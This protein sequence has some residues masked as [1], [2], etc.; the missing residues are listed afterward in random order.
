MWYHIAVTS[1]G[2]KIS[3]YINGCEAFRDYVSDEMKGMYADPEDGRFRVG[4]SWWQESG[5]TLDKF[6]QGNLQE[7]R[8]SKGALEKEQWLIPN[9]EDYVGEYGSNREY[10]LKDEDNYNIVL[11]PDTQNTVEFRPDVMN[12]AVDGLIDSADELNV[13]GVIHLGDVVDDNDDDKQY[14]AAR[15]AFY[16]LPD[17]GM[18]FLVQLGNHDG[19][20]DG[21]HNYYNSFS[22]KSTSF[23]RKTS[24]YLNHS[25]NGDQNSSYMFVEGGSYRYLVISLSCTG[26]GSGSN[27]NTG[28]L[29]ADEQWLRDVLEQ[30]PNCPTIVTT[31]DLQNCSDTEPSS[32]KLSSRGQQLWNIVKDYDQVF[33]MVG[34]HSHGS[35]VEMLENTNGKD[36]ISI[37]TDYQFAYNGGNGFFRYLEFDENAGKIYY[38]T[39]SPYA[40]SL[41]EEEKTFFDVNFMTGNGNEG[42]IDIDFQ[43]RF[44]GM[45]L[46]KEEATEEGKWMTGE[47]HTHTGQ[48]KDASSEFMSLKNVLAAAFRNEQILNDEENAAAK[49]DNLKYGDSFDFLGLADHLRQSYNGTDGNGNGNYNT[50]FYVAAQTQYRE[51]E[52]MKAQGLYNDKMI[53]NGFEWD[54]PGLDH[55]SVGIMDE[56]GEVSFAGIHEFEWKYASTS[57]DPDSLY[58]FADSKGDDFDEAGVYGERKG[59]SKDPQIAYEAV[60]WLEENYPNSYVLPNHS[61]RHNGGSGEVTIENLRRLNDA[62]PN[63]VFGF[64]GMPGNQMSGSGRAELPD[65]DIRNGADEMIAVTGGVWDALLSEG[66]KIYNFANS[67]F[68]FKVSADEKYSSGYWASEYSANHTWVEPGEDQI[69]DY[70]D[71]VE[72]L[73]SGNSYSVYGNLISDLAFTV[74]A[75]DKEATMG[76]ELNTSK[77]DKV[78]VTIRFQ[79]PENN[80][81]ESLYNTDTGLGADNTPDLDHVDLILGNVTGKVDED[82]YASVESDAK[83]VKTFDKEELKAAKGEDGYYTLTFQTEVAQ[84]CY[85]RLRGTSVSEV[86]ENGDP[87]ADKN[88]SGITDNLERFDAINDSN[89][90]SLCFYA[91]PIWIN[92]RE[93]VSVEVLKY[94]LELADEADTD[95]VIEAV[96]EK[97]ETAYAKAQDVYEKALAGDVTVDQKLIDT[98]WRELILSMQYLSFKQG[99]KEDLTSVIRAAQSIDLQQYLEEGQKEFQAALKEAKRIQADGNAMQEEVDTAWKTLLKTMSELRIRPDKSL[100]EELVNTANLL[101]KKDYKTEGFAQFESALASAR[102]VLE[103]EQA[104][105]EEVCLLLSCTEKEDSDFT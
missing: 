74:K 16:R 57:D 53:F 76:E 73:R 80:N 18:K 99:D 50:A 62:A 21:I 54:M 61:S 36:V 93:E 19:W 7:V 8:I 37:L 3:T 58:Q 79:V 17:A 10:K 72:G 85:F 47:Y 89:Y 66:R 68:H 84:N 13:K 81:Y 102:G 96:K 87:L 11:I 64:E 55:A 32:I 48:S 52:N 65:G 42:A 38:S 97:F 44:P 14:M 103:D 12:A 45:E 67:D 46:V 22:G 77:G 20:S 70:K 60:E 35:G 1:D 91:N 51:I 34:G 69:Y 9:P 6:L 43:K 83:I 100:L 23:T 39:Y 101:I 28:W 78:T 63:V 75:N 90:T 5:Q 33:M 98:S 29:A 24:W 26:S 15:D 71:V 4:S 2:Q 31:H 30:Y 105:L 95:N 92:T 27:N 59:G 94:A 49:F 86:D 41:P 88:Y 82:S 25:P 40:A 56:N 104:T